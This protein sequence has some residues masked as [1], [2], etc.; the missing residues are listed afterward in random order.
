[1][2]SGKQIV[3]L[4]YSGAVE[5]KSFQEMRD[6]HKKDHKAISLAMVPVDY[7]K[8]SVREFF[9]MEPDEIVT[10]VSHGTVTYEMQVEIAGVDTDP[11][12]I[13]LHKE[14]VEIN[15]PSD[16][17]DVILMIKKIAYFNTIINDKYSYD[18]FTILDVTS[19]SINIPDSS[20]GPIRSE[21]QP[22]HMYTGGDL[23]ADSISSSLDE[24]FGIMD[25]NDCIEYSYVCFNRNDTEW[26]YTEDPE[27]RRES[28]HYLMETEVQTVVCI[29][30]RTAQILE[31]CG[32]SG[33]YTMYFYGDVGFK[34]DELEDV[35][36]V[37]WS[38]YAKYKNSYKVLVDEHVM[39]NYI[40]TRL[41]NQIKPTIGISYV[42]NGWLREYSKPTSKTLP[43]NGKPGWTHYE[44]SQI[45][46]CCRI[47]SLMLCLPAI[48]YCSKIFCE[49]A[50]YFLGASGVH[51]V[52]SFAGP[53]DLHG[54]DTTKYFVDPLVRLVPFSYNWEFDYGLDKT[55]SG[56]Q[57][58]ID[59]MMV[60]LM[61]AFDQHIDANH[62]KDVV[63]IWS[64]N[65][66][67]E[68]ELPF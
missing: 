39:Y 30:D 11:E 68:K 67:Q 50:Q 36:S 12:L 41:R 42:V 66:E 29:D 33:Q 64:L 32:H 62:G 65:V 5:Y 44:D 52:F 8:C 14:T 43:T 4:K 38:T 13:P 20:R 63:T 56:Y 9:L 25:L 31:Y 59:L 2:K 6:V 40:Q 54:V 49:V 48:N 17:Y 21:Y 34:F 55:I 15:R 26:F 24:D 45:S 27:T 53:T 28:A 37:G 57:S 16:L 60:E 61:H 7:G 3:L 23:H 18:G 35:P 1:M 47:I 10:W 58:P 22:R 19:V 46:A 51:Y